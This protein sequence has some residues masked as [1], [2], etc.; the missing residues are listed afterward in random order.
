MRTVKGAIAGIAM[1]SA[2]A[3]PALADGDGLSGFH[4]VEI[5]VAVPSGEGTP[6][7]IDPG[8]LRAR[9]G[10]R[11][12][13]AGIPIGTSAL[14]LRASVTT[15]SDA[16]QGRCISAVLLEAYTAQTT[17]LQ[18]TRNTIVANI[19]L[20]RATSIASSDAPGHNERVASAA[21][22]ITEKF[23]AAFR[24]NQ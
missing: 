11:L 14:S 17:V 23:A 4:T 10:E 9:I 15:L 24:A 12:Q 1:M 6:C 20:W 2:F 5:Q 16:I 7:A 3:G 22:I 13:A 21:A 19:P 18:A 8:L